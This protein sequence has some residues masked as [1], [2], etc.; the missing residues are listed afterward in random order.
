[1]KIILISIFISSHYVFAQIPTDFNKQRNKIDKKLMLTLTTWSS[2]NIIASS[3]GWA[4]AGNGEAKYFHQMN[5]TWSAINI[6]LALP[7]YF[8]ARN[9]NAQISLGNTLRKQS[10]TEQAFLFNTGLDIAYVTAGFLLKSEGK[11]NIPKQAQFNGFGNGLLLQGGFLFLFDLSAYIIHRHHAAL[12]NPTL[13]RLT[14]S[15]SGIGLKW[16]IGK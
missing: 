14:M 2:A 6:G 8:K 11:H 12:L 15:S 9:S 7:G 4:T 16:R 10:E 13:D 1:M 5:V 3:I